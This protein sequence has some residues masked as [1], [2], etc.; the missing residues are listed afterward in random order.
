MHALWIAA[1]VIIVALYGCAD[2][3]TNAVQYNGRGGDH[4]GAVS[5]GGAVHGRGAA[6]G[7]MGHG[8]IGGRGGR[9][10]ASGGMGRGNK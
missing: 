6:S 7:G 1:V 5:T 2:V 8:S 9:G 10:A 3:P 4:A